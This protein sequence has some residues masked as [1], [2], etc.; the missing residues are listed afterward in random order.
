M[1]LFLLSCFICFLGYPK[2]TSA[3]EDAQSIIKK[4]QKKYKSIDNMSVQ[5]D[6]FFKWKLTGKS[7]SLQGKMFF[8]KENN[9]RYELGQQLNVTNGETVW[10]YSEGSNQVIIDK[11]KKNSKSLFMPKYFMYEYLEKFIAEIIAHETIKG[12]EVYVL[13][14]Y[15]KDKDDFVQNMKVWVPADTWIAD[16]F[17]YS[18]LEGNQIT[19]QFTNIQID[20]AL[21]MKLFNFTVE[22]G[23]DV[24]DLR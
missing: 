3:G 2:L 19:Y 17:E 23:I 5:F 13:K 6:Y 16:K 24:I 4:V 18:D 10:Q 7:Q 8:K 22:S 1:R 14:M 9:I 11:L 20:T 15:P 21:D 12:R